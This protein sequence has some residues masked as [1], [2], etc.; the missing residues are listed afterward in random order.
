MVTKRYHAELKLHK[1]LI[2]AKIHM[3]TKHT[4]KEETQPKSL[5]LAKIHMVT[6]HDYCGNVSAD[7]LF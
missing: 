3:V 1:C 4:L 7:C 5:I 6:K 2:L